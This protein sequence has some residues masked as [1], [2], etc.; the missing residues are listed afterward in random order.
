MEL[1]VVFCFMRGYDLRAVISRLMRCMLFVAGKMFV[2]VLF[3]S[4]LHA[5]F[6]HLRV[7]K[8]FK[9]KQCMHKKQLEHD[10]C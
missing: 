2:N 10:C 8:C 3:H 6:S 1:L 9:T 5:V 4:F 7:S